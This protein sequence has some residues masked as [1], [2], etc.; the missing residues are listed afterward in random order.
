MFARAGNFNTQS[1]KKHCIN[2]E[3]HRLNMQKAFPKG[4]FLDKKKTKKQKTLPGAANLKSLKTRI[5]PP[6]MKL[7]EPSTHVGKA[8]SSHLL[9]QGGA[10]WQLLLTGKARG[11]R[12]AMGT[13]GC[14]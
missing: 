14:M 13:A 2:K 12:L 1:L 10:G 7:Q 4:P 5:T 11:D 8:D 3:R 9:L 6:Q